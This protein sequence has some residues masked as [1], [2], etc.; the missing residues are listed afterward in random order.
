MRCN[1]DIYA[2]VI[3]VFWDQFVW[4]DQVTLSLCGK[5][6]KYCMQY[7]MI[8]CIY[9]TT[10]GLALKVDNNSNNDILYAGCPSSVS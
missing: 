3:E 9:W 2:D 10:G 5:H 1:Y 8:K 6:L 4:A 7:L